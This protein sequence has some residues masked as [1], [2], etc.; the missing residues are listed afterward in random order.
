MRCRNCG[1]PIM[2]ADDRSR[3]LHDGT[4]SSLCEPTYAEPDPE[5]GLP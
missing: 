4:W 1:E 5:E 2:L 3:W